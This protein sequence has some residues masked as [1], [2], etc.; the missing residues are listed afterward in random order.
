M[1]LVLAQGLDFYCAMG[2][3]GYFA[4]EILLSSDR[5]VRLVGGLE[6]WHSDLHT[7]ASYLYCYSARV[8]SE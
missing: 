7:A 5:K 3:S 4:V 2:C 8:L 6:N 1:L